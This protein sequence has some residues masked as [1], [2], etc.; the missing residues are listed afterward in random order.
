MIPIELADWKSIIAVLGGLGLVVAAFRVNFNIKLDV[1]DIVEQ[2][3]FH[4]RESQQIRI[5]RECPHVYPIQLTPEWVNPGFRSAFVMDEDGSYICSMC[6]Q[7]GYTT[8]EKISVIEA[9][10]STRSWKHWGDKMERRNKI[11]GIKVKTN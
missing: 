4:R 9:Y 8:K 6:S 1:N 11:A 7:S 3:I 5:E 10:W 2:I